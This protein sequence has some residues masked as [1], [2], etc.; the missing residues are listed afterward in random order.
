MHTV[1]FATHENMKRTS[2]CEFFREFK[3]ELLRAH[4]VHSR[5]SGRLTTI[6]VCTIMEI[7]L[8][9]RAKHSPTDTDMILFLN[10]PPSQTK[11]MTSHRQTL[12]G[13]S[14]QAR[15]QADMSSAGRPRLRGAGHRPMTECERSKQLQSQPKELEKRKKK[16]CPKD[17]QDLDMKKWTP[18]T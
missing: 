14:Y 16:I 18:L 12:Y 10:Q 3:G 17:L 6:Y 8:R 9:L 13:H 15:C 1:R 4:V 5:Y 7:G 11:L 2:V